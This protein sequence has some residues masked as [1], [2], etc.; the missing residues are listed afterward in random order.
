MCGLIRETVTTPSAASA[1]LSHQTGSPQELVPI[2]LRIHVGLD[3]DAEVF[4]VDV[5]AGQQ[6][7]LAFG[8]RP[9]VRAHRGDDE[10]LGPQF[11]QR[12]DRGLDDEA[13]VPDAA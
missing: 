8:R 9:A 4:L 2:C 3:R 13:D 6:F 12:L 7:A 5:V 1:F 11:L 10:R